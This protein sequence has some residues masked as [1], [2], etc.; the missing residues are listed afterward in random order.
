MLQKLAQIYVVVH[1]TSIYFRGVRLTPSMFYTSQSFVRKLRLLKVLKRT[2]MW[3]KTQSFLGVTEF[4]CSFC[5]RLQST[6]TPPPKQ[7]KV[8]NNL[9]PNT[10]NFLTEKIS[11]PEPA[12]LHFN[13]SWTLYSKVV[14]MF[15]KCFTLRPPYG[16]K[17]MDLFPGGF[18]VSKLSK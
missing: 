13:K 6:T 15:S 1:I 17:N 14:S 4:A 16:C 3:K 8:T 11:P 10:S 9:Q 18:L 12:F 5:S 2:L 7:N